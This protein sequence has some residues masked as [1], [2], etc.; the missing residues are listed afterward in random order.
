MRKNSHSIRCVLRSS[1]SNNDMMITSRCFTFDIG[2]GASTALVRGIAH[3]GNG[4]SE[5]IADNE[6]MQSKVNYY[7][8]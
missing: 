6:R 2:L 1:C 8:G 7:H 3:A 5:F 4:S